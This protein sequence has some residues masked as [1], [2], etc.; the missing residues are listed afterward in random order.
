[1][2]MGENWTFANEHAIVYTDIELYCCKPEVYIM[3][4]TNLTLT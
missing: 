3:L 2:V 1:M 4:L